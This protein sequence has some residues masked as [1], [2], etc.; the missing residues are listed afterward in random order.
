LPELTVL[1]L[2][3]A[4]PAACGVAWARVKRRPIGPRTIQ[5]L[6]LAGFALVYFLTLGGL[7]LVY[8]FGRRILFVNE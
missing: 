4:V 7:G 6:K 2:L 8:S 3:V 5:L 1:W